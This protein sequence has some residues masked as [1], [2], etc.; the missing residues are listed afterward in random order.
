[1]HD[2]EVGQERIVRLACD[3][4]LGGDDGPEMAA[5]AGLSVRGHD[6]AFADRVEAALREVNISFPGR[7]TEIAQLGAVR[8]KC[9]SMLDGA[10]RPRE[11]ARWAHLAI[12][13]G[14][15]VRL[16]RLLSLMTPTTQPNMCLVL[17]PWK[18]STHEYMLRPSSC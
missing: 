13:H 3:L 11:L 2:P 17:R 15:H 18:T 16:R 5:L 14:G 6:Y 10:I 12:G 8:A 1:V 9:R 4:L 7:G